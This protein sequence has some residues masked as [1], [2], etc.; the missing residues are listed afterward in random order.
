MIISRKVFVTALKFWINKSGWW[1][2]EA[3]LAQISL[4]LTDHDVTPIHLA[5]EEAL[6]DAR[7]L[8]VALMG[9]EIVGLLPL[10][11]VLQAAD[12]YIARDN[13]M[14][15][16]EEHKVRLAIDRLGF[17]ALHPFDPK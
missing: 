8:N 9:S 3:N 6:K 11:A 13:L 7:E 14:I 1:L 10:R 16:E 17:S 12:Y 2:E 5:Y 15:L 4:N